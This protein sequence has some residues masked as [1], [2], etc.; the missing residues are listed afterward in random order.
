M[1]YKR[2][3]DLPVWNEAIELA[4]QVYTLTERVQFRRRRSL[5]DEY[6]NQAS[7]SGRARARGVLKRT[8]GNPREEPVRSGFI[9]ITQKITCRNPLN[10]INS[11][12]VSA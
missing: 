12:V 4:V 9:S 6:E 7:D 2:F 5:R 11:S 3:E 8:G 10:T 1:R